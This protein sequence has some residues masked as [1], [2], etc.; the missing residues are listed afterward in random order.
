MSPLALRLGPL[1]V[2]ARRITR[3]GLRWLVADGAQVVA[4]Q[5]VAFCNIAIAGGDAPAF[6]EEGFDLQVVLAPKLAGRIR[7]GAAS[8]RG[9]YVDRLPGAA[10]DGEMIWAQLEV[11]GDPAI[12]AREPDSLFLA[13]RRFTDIAEDR[14]GPMT[15]WHDRLRAWWGEGVGGTLLGAGICEQD[16]VLRGAGVAFAGLF[17]ALAGP[18]HIVLSQDEPLVPSAGVLAE[19]LAR[20]PDDVMAIRDDMARGLLTQDVAPGAADWLFAG[21]LL[22][23]LERAPLAEAHDLLMRGGL[24]RTGPPDAVC[25][26]LTA[27]L[28]RVARHRRLGYTL[29]CHNFRLAAA[30]PAIRRWFRAAFE[31]VEHGIDD[32]LRDYR[33]LLTALDG[34]PVFVVNALSSQGWE[35]IRQYRGLDD[36]TLQGL[37]GLRAKTLN[38]MLHD[39]RQDFGVEIVDADAI[40]ADLGMAA[41]MPDGVHG[42]GLFYGEIRAELARLL[43]AR[44]VAGFVSRS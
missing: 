33:A 19:Q 18:A 7:H 14:S 32:V 12:D 36:R 1:A 34:R 10:W 37:A 43:A 4:H 8:S 29:N 9:G 15:G 41:H 40:A 42:S 20:R 21:A 27:E 6:A 38:L 28:P 23:A 44:G 25:L 39:L 17:G 35:R 22:N 30:P 3:S 11:S 16:A 13:G 24:R 31:P 2:P 26:S 5:P